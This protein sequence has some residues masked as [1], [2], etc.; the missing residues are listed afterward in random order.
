MENK[1]VVGIPRGMLYYRYETLWRVFFREIGVDFIISEPTRQDTAERGS[2]LAVDEACLSLKL[3]L[4][5]V[6]ALVGKCE[7]ILIPRINSYGRNQ[8]LCPRFSALYDIAV[9]TFRDKGQKFLPFS[10]DSHKKRDGTG[11]LSLLGSGAGRTAPQSQK[12]L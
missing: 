10:M 9:N 6:D 8:E 4:G 1:A 5:H 7:Y 3:F 11:C 12:G 2:A